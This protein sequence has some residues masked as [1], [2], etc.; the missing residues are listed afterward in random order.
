MS[1]LY[2]QCRLRQASTEVT[3]WIPVRLNRSYVARTDR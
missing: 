2:R 3:A 1:D